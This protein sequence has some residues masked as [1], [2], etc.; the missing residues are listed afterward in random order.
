MNRGGEVGWAA[1][2]NLF[3]PYLLI[4]HHLIIGL[5]IDDKQ[6]LI[7]VFGSD[8]LSYLIAKVSSHN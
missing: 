3:N 7:L 4:T 6:Q 1:A 5:S 2:V 8:L